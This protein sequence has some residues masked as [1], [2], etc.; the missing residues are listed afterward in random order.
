MTEPSFPT[1]EVTPE[2]NPGTPYILYLTRRQVDY[3]VEL[4]SAPSILGGSEIMRRAQLI[5]ALEQALP[6]ADYNSNIL[7]RHGYNLDQQQVTFLPAHKPVKVKN[8]KPIEAESP[9]EEPFETLDDMPKT[10]PKHKW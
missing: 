3:L 7:K 4:I 9:V 8:K 10:P 1:P 5:G 2:I 6:A